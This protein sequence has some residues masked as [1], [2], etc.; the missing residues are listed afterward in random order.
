MFLWSL[1][2]TSYIFPFINVHVFICF[3]FFEITCFHLLF[4]SLSFNWIIFFM[5]FNF[6]F[7]GIG[8]CSCKSYQPCRISSQR[9][10]CSKLVLKFW[11]I[12]LMPF[13]F[14]CIVKIVSLKLQINLFPK[15]LIDEHVMLVVSGVIMFCSM[16]GCSYFS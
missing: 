2:P 11:W 16:S 9:T 15:A 4:P 6:L 13:S 7:E 14:S 8:Y 1:F 10:S 5:L 12:T 3:L